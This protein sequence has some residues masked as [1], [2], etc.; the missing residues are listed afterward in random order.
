MSGKMR[1]W[2]VGRAAMAA[3]GCLVA[4]MTQLLLA[5]FGC[6]NSSGPKTDPNA[7]V[8]DSIIFDY[9]IGIY[10]DS[11]MTVVSY[12]STDES[13]G[14]FGY[15]FSGM[16]AWAKVDHANDSAGLVAAQGWPCA[17]VGRIYGKNLDRTS[18]HFKMGITTWPDYLSYSDDSTYNGGCSYGFYRSKYIDST[19]NNSAVI[20]TIKSGFYGCHFG[21]NWFWTR[22][23]QD[24]TNKIY[25][26]NLNFFWLM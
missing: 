7:P 20:F 12:D 6:S 15:T 2:D 18:V 16:D 9:V 3:L 10:Q 8:V 24:S 11:S 23:Y 21:G 1:N 25:E 17:L 4:V 19:G 13:K 26:K 22:I 5:S 14:L